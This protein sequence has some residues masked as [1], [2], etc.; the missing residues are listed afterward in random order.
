MSHTLRGTFYLTAVALLIFGGS[1]LAQSDLA[2]S[3]TKL[4]VDKGI[5]AVLGFSEADAADV[6]K[7]ASKDGRRVYFQSNDAAAAKAVRTSAEKAQLLTVRV[8]VDTGPLSSIHLSENLADGVLVAEAAADQ[9]S[10]A[11]VLRV[12]RPLGIAIIGN[13]KLVKPVPAGMDDWSHPYHGPDNNPQSNDQL[14]KG[15]FQTQFIADP[16][17]SPMPEQ[18]VIAGGR[19]FKAMGH[20]AHKANQNEMLN[21]LL[22]INAYNGTILW[23]R[24]LPEGFMI[25]RNTMIAA[26][27]ALYLGDHESCKVI[28]ARTGEATREIKIGEDISDGPTWKWMAMQDD[29]LFA[30]VGN[31]EIKVETMRSSRRGLGH[32][33]WGMWKGHDYKDPRT[34]FGHGRTF[35]ALDR[36]T[37]KQLWH[38][39][40]DEF[41]DARAVCMKND[42]IYVCS[43]EH[44]LACLDAKTGKLLW[45]NTDKDLLAAIGPNEKAQHYITGYATTCYMKCS[46]DLLF[47]SGPQRKEMV[48]ASAIDGKLKWTNAVGNLQLVLRD[49]AVYAAGPQKVSGMRLDYQTGNVL[50]SFPARRAC[51]RAT[52]C[53]D[54]IFFRASGG[55][56][57]V[58][59]ESNKATHIAPMRPPCQDGVLISNGHLYWGPWMC[60]C[61]LSLYGN[62]GL[63]P[64][65]DSQAHKHLSGEDL[66]ADALTVFG[67]PS[68]VPSLDIQNADWTT[69]RGNNERSD[70]TSNA[71]PDGIKLAWQT[72]I[73]STELPTAPVAA[74]GLV[75]IADR[76]GIVRAIDNSG[77]TVWKA[78]TAGPVYYPPSVA[79]DRVFVGCAD[80][81]VYAFAAKT[82]RPLW[83]F[84]VA[85][86]D[87]WISVYDRLLSRWPVAGGVV[88]D[89]GTVYAAAGI[90]H[91][92]GTYLVGLDAVTGQLTAHNDSS[93]KLSEQVDSGISMQGNLQIVDGEL[94]FLGGGVYETARYDLASLECLNEPRSDVSSQFRTAFYPYYPSYGKY[95]SLEY[96]CGDGNTLCHDASYEGSMF[97][98]LSLQTPLPPG[99]KGMVKDAAREFLRRRGRGAAVPKDLWKDKADRRFTSFVVTEDRL[100]GAGH[101]DEKPEESFLAA[102]NV[103]DGSD[104]WVQKLPATAVK[105]GIAVDASGKIL[106]SLEN[107]QLLCFVNAE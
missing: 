58:M 104:L 94:R 22:C 19:I 7:L 25:H 36:K 48:V 5:I 43:P 2:T 76:T 26:D 55:T 21:T 78:Y 31:L 66:Y 44:F 27:D 14:V 18:T 81:R 96:K 70:K 24:P 6:V 54:S 95:V 38:Y 65:G 50:A 17:F 46:D 29:I 74:G 89:N 101:P 28:D 3:A 57:R 15:A 77:K 37:G 91:Y 42:K 4:Q 34:A 75:F 39:R 12:L 68:R 11:E 99:T 84:R 49:D 20:I 106:V 47:F 80:G 85:P 56:V 100:L 35:V 16:K 32:W 10:D 52:G 97:G 41:L 103:K 107:G 83:T 33:P 51:T 92:D 61:Q 88:I 73:S 40:D 30:L 63:K 72:E 8:S 62:I 105:G 59:T 13:R 102:I 71:L 93:G 87:R 45:R 64:V 60:G 67:D 53:A 69:W 90:T 86:Q 82:G 98:N 9:V 79:K 23:R 1:A